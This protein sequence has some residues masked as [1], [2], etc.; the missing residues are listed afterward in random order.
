MVASVTRW[1]RTVALSVWFVVW[2]MAA[3]P[4]ADA[5]LAEAHDW[6][7]RRAMRRAVVTSFA[8][9]AFGVLLI[10]GGRQ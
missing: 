10:I 3:R 8:G 4:P 6:R 1:A 7:A 5:T 2:G 9:L